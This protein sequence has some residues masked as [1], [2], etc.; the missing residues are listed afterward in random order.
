MESGASHMREIFDQLSIPCFYGC[1]LF[2]QPLWAY[3]AARWLTRRRELHKRP[4]TGWLIGLGTLAGIFL[5]GLAGIN[6]TL[7]LNHQWYGDCPTCYEYTGL[8]S[9][10]HYGSGI[11]SLIIFLVTAFRGIRR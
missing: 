3:L 8:A 5:T 10:I 1:T 11:I 6:L 7:R 4:L 9:L 2:L